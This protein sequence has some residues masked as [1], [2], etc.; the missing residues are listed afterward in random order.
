MWMGAE[1][2]EQTLDERFNVDLVGASLQRLQ[3]RGHQR[4]IVLHKRVGE[5]FLDRRWSCAPGRLLNFDVTLL[6]CFSYMTVEAI[7][8]KPRPEA[9]LFA[10]QASSRPCN[11]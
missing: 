10:Y 3:V 8:R 9:L 2:S 6:R 1:Q 7:A 4:D 11:R 5:C